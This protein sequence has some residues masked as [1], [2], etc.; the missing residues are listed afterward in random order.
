MNMP[1]TTM[2]C[3]LLTPHRL[4]TQEAFGAAEMWQAVRAGR[5]P[6]ADWER[7][8][9]AFEVLA[10][11]Q[12]LRRLQPSGFQKVDRKIRDDVERL[13]AEHGPELLEDS[14]SHADDALADVDER[15]EN[16]AAGWDAV[17]EPPPDVASA[18][19]AAD[20]EEADE[21][22]ADV[23]AWMRLDHEH[24]LSGAAA[25]LLA[26]VDRA[27]LWC[28]AALRLAH[29]QGQD[30]EHWPII[31]RVMNRVEAATQTVE[32]RMDVFAPAS[33]WA[34]LMASGLRT[35][36]EAER[37]PAMAAGV[38]LLERLADT[39]RELEA[40][41]LGWTGSEEDAAVAEV[42]QPLPMWTKAF[43]LLRVFSQETAARSH[44]T[45]AAF[46]AVR[47]E[48][49]L[50]VKDLL[51]GVRVS[52]AFQVGGRE[53]SPPSINDMAV[54]R[55]R[56]PDGALLATLQVP[57]EV[58]EQDTLSLRLHHPDKRPARLGGT[59]RLGRLPPHEFA[60]GAAHVAVSAVLGEG[61]RLID[62]RVSLDAGSEQ[63]WTF[64]G[65]DP[66]LRLFEADEEDGDNT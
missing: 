21:W 37:E 31:E 28:V 2:E 51:A 63:A 32:D 11:W 41:P 18:A 38:W 47:R 13:V 52:E 8:E 22:D 57:R 60:E 43:E 34:S 64:A 61:E 30:A 24:D 56:S 35:D 19:D 55:W 39:Q 59:F 14:T 29:E 58:R 9:A 1:T 49:A 54:L 44:A 20:D 17:E 45:A 16:L 46:A 66:E 36:D 65:N 26:E 10:L 7:A 4:L 42:A 48:V 23:E 5:E 12:G 33:G 25:G 6:A 50:A 62:L 3:P 40:G 53:A 15:V 27:D